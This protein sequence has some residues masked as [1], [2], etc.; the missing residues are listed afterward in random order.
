MH[1]NIYTGL[2]ILA[3]PD[4]LQS[5][6]AATC[7]MG[8]FIPGAMEQQG[9]WGM[10]THLGSTSLALWG[11]HWHSMLSLRSVRVVPRL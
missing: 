4:A 10:G 5:A 8:A 3:S 1:S 7:R 11:A 2:I 6:M 9:T